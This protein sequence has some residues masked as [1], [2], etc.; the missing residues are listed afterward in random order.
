MNMNTE[1]GSRS[2][3]VWARWKTALALAVLGMAALPH[4][5]ETKGEEMSYGE[6]R[7]FI[8]KHTNL[9]ELTGPGGARVAV[10]PEWQGRVMTS[11]CGGE[12]G[13]SFG[14]VNRGFI[15]WGQLDKR[16][17]NYGAEDRMWLSPEGG[18]FSLWFAPGAE[19]TL[20]HWYTADNMNNGAYELVAPPDGSTCRMKREMKL[21]NASATKFD[22]AV[23]RDVRLLGSDD[24]ANL[25]GEAAGL[26]QGDDVNLVAYETANSIRNNGPAMTREGGL[27]SIWMLGMLN[28][29]PETV[30]V[31]PYRPGDESELGPVVKSDYFGDVPAERLKVLPEAILFRAD[32]KFRAKIGTSQRRAKNVL[33]SIDFAAGTLTI[34]QFTMPDDPTKHDYMNNM[35]GFDTP[36]PYVG[37]V[38][39][40][41]NDGP[42]E[43]GG[44]AFGAFYEIES[45]SHAAALATGE[46]LTHCHRTLHLQASP[47]KLDAVSRA[48]FGIGLDA[49]RQAMLRE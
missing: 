44:E 7:E 4:G 1:G 23:T 27:V 40:A 16:F 8:A 2:G 34:V 47:E 45:L 20:D 39:N 41:Y 21:Q 32:A 17:N 13:A 36:D 33:G 18:R 38:A 43:P 11:S 15:E 9:V 35:W 26:M 25:F 46:S 24:L 28:S 3:T 48:V 6:V 30:I 10:C 42:P 29:G 12:D 14:F 5:T 37:D 49:I 19:Q 22:F 31:V